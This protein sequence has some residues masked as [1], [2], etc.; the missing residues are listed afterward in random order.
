MNF[1][2][3]E[4]LSKEIE[5]Q[6]NNLTTDRLDMSYGELINLYEKDEIII[7]PNFQRLFRWDI[8]KRSRFIE[9]ILLGIPVPPIF[10]AEDEN[11]VWELVDGL[12]RIS[13][14][15]SFFGKLKNDIKENNN[16]RLDSGT[17]ISKMEGY[18]GNDFPIKYQ[19]N[20]QRT[21]CRVEIIKW[22]SEYDMRY[23][24]F[25]RLNTGGESLTQQEIRN[26][27]YRGTSEK[28]N[29]LLE[30]L[31]ERTIFKNL[32]QLT[33]R[34][35]ETLYHQELVLRFFSLYFTELANINSKNMSLFMTN[36]MKE[37]IEDRDF[38]YKEAS[39]IFEETFNLLGKLDSSIFRFSN[40]QFSTS[41]YDALT[42]SIAKNLELFKSVD[43][44][45]INEWIV[46][47]KENDDFRKYV[48]SAAS[49]KSRIVK[50]MEI[51]FV[52][53]GDKLDGNI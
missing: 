5:L 1:I 23:E 20:I 15:L 21:Y 43:I 11:G 51:A 29:E 28:F 25:N 45:S 44:E 18:T 31:S 48:G 47:L 40:N 35:L 36:F 42:V 24:L 32:I 33:D 53:F 30:G 2:T 4:E 22:D 10:V 17:L 6:R 34:Q 41:L 19:R 14:I 26:C 8:D 13:T 27:I 37:T 52:F 7:D 50:R 12:Q 39:N 38:D 46:E 3:E 49:S 9:S 16:W